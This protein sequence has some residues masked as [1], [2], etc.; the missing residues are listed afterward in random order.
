[1]TNVEFNYQGHIIFIQC[2][3]NDK[4]E[5]IIQNFCIKVQ[6]SKEQLYFLYGGQ[7]ISNYSLNFIE[8]ASQ[9]DKSRKIMSILVIDNYD[10]NESSIQNW[11]IKLKEKLDKANKTI[12]EQK[13]EIQDLKYQI[14]MNK[15]ESISQINNLMNTIEKKDEQINKL[16]EQIKN[17]YC[18]KC[19]EKINLNNNILFKNDKKIKKFHL[20]NDIIHNSESSIFSHLD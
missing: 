7:I 16:K 20:I 6:K 10:N 3:E 1:M 2:N 18:P 19:K 14:T 17:I 13:A 9:I 12:S 5:K 15:S 4:L 11:N 8:L